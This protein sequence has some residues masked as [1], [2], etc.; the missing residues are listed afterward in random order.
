MTVRLNQELCQKWQRL[1]LASPVTM[2]LAMKSYLRTVRASPMLLARMSALGPTVKAI[3]DRIVLTIDSATSHVPTFNS[4]D[5][6]SAFGMNIFERSELEDSSSLWGKVNRLA[7][8]QIAA[9]PRETF[10]ARAAV[11]ICNMYLAPFHDYLAAAID[12]ESDIAHSLQ[13]FGMWAHWF[14]ADELRELVRIEEER[15]A[16]HQRPRGIEARLQRRVF[17]WLF[18][19]FEGLTLREVS[20]PSGRP[21]FVQFAVDGRTLPIEAKVLTGSGSHGGDLCAAL[22]QIERYMDDFSTDFGAIVLF[23]KS[24][25]G[26]RLGIS[27]RSSGE[28]P[29]LVLDGGR[30]VYVCLVPLASRPSASKDSRDLKVIVEADFRCERVDDTA[31]GPPVS[32]QGSD[33]T[34]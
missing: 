21:D 17:Q 24:E 3:Q 15:A 2:G 31:V 4:D 26:Y 7:N 5:E 22:R 28:L 13:R 32:E 23:D 25:V 34:L 33:Q 29:C 16:I 14:G 19:D 27:A 6:H 11:H 12:L 8:A 1:L 20:V 18:S 10:P 30:R 9:E